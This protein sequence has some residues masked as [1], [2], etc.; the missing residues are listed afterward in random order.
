MSYWGKLMPCSQP[1]FYNHYSA[2]FPSQ[3]QSFHVHVK[4]EMITVRENGAGTSSAKCSNSAQC[5]RGS[6]SQIK[7]Q[8]SC[9]NTE[10]TLP[11]CP[12]PS[13]GHCGKLIER[14]GG[15]T[16]MGRKKK[17]RITQLL[18]WLSAKT[19]QKNYRSNNAMSIM[20]IQNIPFNMFILLFP[21][22]LV[23]A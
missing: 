12:R 13:Q 23:L 20:R 15:K 1:N 18:L 21:H 14:C 16:N 19:R 6:T 4:C 22:I 11:T 5:S 2:S 3:L 7:R 9:A 17:S 8:L 10:V